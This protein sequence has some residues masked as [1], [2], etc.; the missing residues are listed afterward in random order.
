M[1]TPPQIDPTRKP[2]RSAGE[3]RR[4]PVREMG[5][6]RVTV[7]IPEAQYKRLK[8]AAIEAR[9]TMRQLILDLLEREGITNR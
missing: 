7:D 2:E 4:K 8:Y 1:R 6:A 5:L 3:W 9:T